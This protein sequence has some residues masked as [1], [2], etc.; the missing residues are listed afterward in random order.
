MMT[1]IKITI[2]I[3]ISAVLFSCTDVVDV[4]VQEASP[5]LVIEASLDWTKGTQ[6]NQ[7]TIK[8][9]TSTPYFDANT[10]AIVT[11]ASV[12]VSND[13]DGSEFIFTD[14][15]NGEY[16]T[17]SFIPILN[18][19]Y[20][21]EVVY[22][23]ETYI[24]QENLLPVADIEEV[25]QSTESGF[26]DEALEV[27]IEFNDP[28]AIENFYLI[29][30]KVQG[31]LFPILYNIS[32]EFTDGNLMKVFYEREEDEDINQVEFE[33]GD[34]VDIKFYGI[35]EQYYNYMS[36]LISQYESGGDIFNATPVAIKGNC[37]NQ[38]QKDNY[39]FGYFRLTQVEETDYTFY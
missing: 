10:T 7:Q 25:Y 34:L 14:Q 18:H 37:I 15:N 28:E 24:A 31:D 9:S 1:L 30:F 3:S 11:G 39:A 36:L 16:S 22:N 2:L 27:N 6:G 21:L 20:T 23:N 35:S 8:L 17:T 19:S 12:K 5:R 26:N 4:D 38:T 33:P 32:D 13:T 29:K